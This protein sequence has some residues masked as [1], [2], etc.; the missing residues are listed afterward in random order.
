[1]QGMDNWC[2]QCL[3]ESRVY[4]RNAKTILCCRVT[5]FNAH[6]VTGLTPIDADG[7]LDFFIDR[8]LGMKA[9]S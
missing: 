5:L 2:P 7:Y 8:P 1:M 3:Q 6:L 9:I 4:G